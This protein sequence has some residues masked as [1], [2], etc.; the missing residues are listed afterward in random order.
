MNC[1]LLVVTSHH[2]VFGRALVKVYDCSWAVARASLLLGFGS[3]I[4]HSGAIA[5][6]F[7][8]AGLVLAKEQD[9]A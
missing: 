6:V 8:N 1:T 2:V 9:T 3:R 5:R 4:N 7:V